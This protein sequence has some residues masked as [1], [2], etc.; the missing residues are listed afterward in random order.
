M[1]KGITA[2]HDC[3]FYC[4]NCFHSYPSKGALEKHTKVCES[5]DY[6]YTEMPKKGELL[7]YQPGIKSMKAPFII[8]ADIGF[9]LKKMDTCSNDADKSS[10]NKINKHE[11]SGYSLF[12]SCSFD[13]KTM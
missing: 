12:T 2:K 10:A 4:L 1:L 6:Y 13:K 3:D 7:K 8:V 9:L 11:M 5:K